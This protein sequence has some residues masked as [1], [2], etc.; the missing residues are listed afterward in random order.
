MKIE[1]VK[2]YMERKVWYRDS[3]YYLTGCTLRKMDGKFY[4]Q[5]E[6]MELSGR[7]IL[8][9]ALEKITVGKPVELWIE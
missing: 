1:D 5:A 3:E 9:V 6:L 4:Y 7:S 8:I 2:S